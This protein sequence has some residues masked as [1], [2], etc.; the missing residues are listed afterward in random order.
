MALYDNR[1]NSKAG[2]FLF[3]IH[4]FLAFLLSLSNLRSKS[5]F[6]VF[7]LF[8]ILFGYTFIAQNESADSFGYVQE[9]K[10]AKNSTTSNYLNDIKDYTTFNSKIKD[11]YVITCNYLVT[12]VTDNYHVLLA[13]YAIVFAFFF[14]KSFRFFV[15]RPE[16]NRSYIVYLI[17]FLF[18]F[19][20]PISN[21][22]GVRFY[23]AAWLA[24]Y[25][26]F[27]V[28][29]NKN[30]R[31]LILALIT[32]L[33]HI[34]FLSFIAVLLIYLFSIKYDKFWVVLFVISFFVGN[35]A[36]ELV[37][38]YSAL[39]PQTFQNMAWSYA[40][41]VNIQ[42]RLESIQL[43][44][45]YAK[46]LNK[47]PYLFINALVFIF[48][49]KSRNIKQDKKAYSTYLFLLAWMSFCNFTLPIPSFGG[50]F[51]ALGIPLIMYVSLAAYKQIPLLKNALLLAPIIFSYSI[52]L[53]L[54]FVG[55]IID[56]NLLYQVFPYLIIKNIY[57]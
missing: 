21:I 22:N 24:V 56:I 19:S 20:N 6:V 35:I 39:M 53:W 33:I 40:D 34:S 28:V 47:L 51:I 1:K 44:P 2:I 48:I 14:L 50:R 4:P 9:F 42:K 23:T 57:G 43:L 41:D 29:V 32:P 18:V 49:A 38:N 10:A 30:Y 37:Q 31:F 25:V 15:D 16:L 17:A 8:N 3:F 52:F 12:R 36:V 27:Q 45:L 7:L 5:S 54:R 13:L 11:I 26:I 46:V 55:T